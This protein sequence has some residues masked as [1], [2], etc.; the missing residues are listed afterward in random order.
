[1]TKAEFLSSKLKNFRA[2]VEPYCSTDEQRAALETYNS[3]E[4]VMP[5]LL[6]A[7][8]A[9]RVGQADAVVAKF[10]TEFPNAD[11][12]FRAKISRYLTMFC[13]VLTT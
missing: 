11:D 1:M 13:D 9:Q 8:A 7:V 2:F 3:L 6:Q 10:C 12:A 5:L 4:S